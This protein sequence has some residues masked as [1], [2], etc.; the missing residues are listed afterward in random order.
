VRSLTSTNTPH[1]CGIKRTIPS[2][3]LG[4]EKLDSSSVPAPTTTAA[5]EVKVSRRVFQGEAMLLAI[6]G[7]SALSGEAQ[8]LG[9]K[10]ELKKKKIPIEQYSELGKRIN[11]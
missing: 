4:Q 1:S 8:A 7:T 3:T 2:A 11:Y 9:F 6:L 5:E 10:K